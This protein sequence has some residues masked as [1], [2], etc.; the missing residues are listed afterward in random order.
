MK[1]LERGVFAIVGSIMPSQQQSIKL[2][3]MGL[4]PCFVI[5]LVP[6]TFLL[7]TVLGN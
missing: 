6:L 2:G 1:P 7:G 5:P 4:E 3:S